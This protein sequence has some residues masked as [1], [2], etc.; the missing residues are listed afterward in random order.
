LWLGLSTWLRS[1]STLFTVSIIP[2]YV[3]ERLGVTLEEYILDLVTRDLDP[4]ERARE[5]IEA[6]RNLI[7]RAREELGKGI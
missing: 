5:Y 6:T 3:V 1:F 7:V 4:E 2:L